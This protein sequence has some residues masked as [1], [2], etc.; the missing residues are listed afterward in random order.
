MKQALALF[1]GA[2]MGILVPRFSYAADAPTPSLKEIVER[3]VAHDE[4]RQN[5]LQKMQYDQTANVD[6]LD[7][8]GNVV[9]HETLQMIIYPGGNPNMK[10]VSITGDHIPSD[11]DQ[12]EAQSKGR[13]VEDNKHNFTLRALCDRF[14]L[15]LSDETQLNGRAVH[16]VAFSPKPDQPYADETEKVVNQLHGKMWISADTY[17]V[18]KTEASLAEP[19]SVAWFLATVPKLE[20]HYSRPDTTKEFTPC[21]VQITLQVKAFIVGFYERQTVDMSNFKAR[22]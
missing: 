21:Q 16:V 19:V 8:S 15:S 4:A 13:D 9:K 2:L 7:G 6:E 20:F 18:L 22:N 1:I 17:D 10:V 5:M 14:N 3:T 12:A 11:P